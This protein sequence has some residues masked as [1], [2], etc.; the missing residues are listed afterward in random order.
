MIPLTWQIKG[1]IAGVALLAIVGVG[2]KIYSSGK[3]AGR[4]EGSREQLDIDKQ[5][6]EQQRKS[7]QE[8]LEKNKAVDDAAQAVISQ[9]QALIDSANS[10]LAQLAS[11]RSR[12]AQAVGALPDSGLVADLRKKLNVTPSD[13]APTLN[14]AEMR[15]VDTVVT[16][17]APLR[18]AYAELA[19]K[20]AATDAQVAKL[21]ERVTAISSQRDAA[22]SFANDMVGHY[23]AAYNAAQ[24]HHS[25]LVTVLTFGLVRTKKLNLPDPV[26]L[27]P[28]K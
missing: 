22:L 26:T 1:I 7:F 21:N 3:D 28:K 19:A 4:G 13:T 24:K 8:T 16:D 20:Q 9:Q 12:D 18:E 14:A 17:Y 2:V 23:T 25:K 10:R 15:Q 11:I 5:S 27:A 6:M